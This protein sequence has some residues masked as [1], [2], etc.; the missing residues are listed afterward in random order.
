LY[1]LAN[2]DSLKLR[3][4][5]VEFMLRGIGFPGRGQ[6]PI[7]SP[8]YEEVYRDIVDRAMREFVLNI[9]TFD[10]KIKSLI[11]GCRTAACSR[12]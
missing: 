8:V 6:P 11:S 1:G 3:E 9:K 2:A 4:E 7:G 10:S 5:L 12:R